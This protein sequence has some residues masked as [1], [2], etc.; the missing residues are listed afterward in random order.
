MTRA[1]ASASQWE[2][3]LRRLLSQFWTRLFLSAC[4]V[5]SLLPLPWVRELEINP[6]IVDE[7]GAIVAD[8][9]IV[10][11]HG[12]PAGSDRYAHVAIHPY[13][14]HLA[15][16]WKMSDGRAVRVRPVRP[17]DGGM[18]Q[19]FFDTMS[20]ETRYFRFMEAIDEL[21]A[22]LIARFTQID[23]DREMALIATSTADGVERQ[24]GSARYTLAPDGEAV[25]F[26][27][28]LAGL[29]A[30]LVSPGSR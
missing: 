30:H 29:S 14:A 21:P 11:D 17:E 13:P 16:D 27:P 28:I 18:L 7:L 4:I 19:Q 22:S 15:Q 9:R 26:V 12:L 24:V 10:I 1:G 3:A 23:Y 25:E 8:A 2:L 20:A 5:M 6:L